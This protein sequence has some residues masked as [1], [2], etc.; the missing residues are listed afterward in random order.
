MAR[1]PKRVAVAF[2]VLAFI[3]VLVFRVMWPPG[4]ELVCTRMLDGAIEQWMIENHSSNWFP[5]IG[6]ESSASLAVLLPYVFK[7][8]LR[9]HRYVAGLRR[10]DPPS[11]IMCYV[12]KPTSRR[13]HGER[14]NIFRTNGWIIAGP[15]FDSFG[16]SNVFEAHE[17]VG[18]EEFTNRLV[19]TLRFLETNQ[20]PH[21]QQ[22]VASHQKFL[23]TLR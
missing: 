15:G 22:V 2:G 5:N 19:T 23:E 20:R 14:A 11:L 8:D 21:W 17:W 4:P 18:T 7:A 3:W 12:V 1:K 10:E 16:S 13:W 6:G 9:D